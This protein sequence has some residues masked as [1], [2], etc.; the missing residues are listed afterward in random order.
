MEVLSYAVR[1]AITA[2]PGRVLYVADYAAIE[3]RVLLWLAG[4]EAALNI[5]RGGGDIYLEMAETIYD[6]PCSKSEHPAE[7]ALGK[8]AVLGL[9]YQM[10]ASKFVDTAFLMGGV[11]I[12]EE[13]AQ[14][15]VDAYRAKFPLVKAMWYATE[16]AAIEA[17]CMGKPVV[18][19]YTTWRMAG[20]FLQCV[21]PSGR[22]LS[23]PDPQV[24]P[25][26][27][28]WGEMKSQ[29]TFM[30]THPLSHKW[31]R[32]HSYGGSLVENITQAVARDLMAAALL[33]CEY[34]DT[35]VP[36][37]SVH[38]ELIA[39]AKVGTGSVREFEE[40]MAALPDW[41]EGLPVTA[42]GWTGFRYHK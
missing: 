42:E 30:G 10:G 25:K 7:R 13:M 35:Y 24:K 1:G 15:V 32:Q 23:Y 19:G 31:V 26:M 40:L 18:N 38:D 14:Q 16:E 28:P 27:T 9:G 39:E 4:D 34:S 12:D 33:R 21:L 29:L 3:A 36:V 37:L 5:F 20:R 2:S 22:A 11:T 6:H 41:A 17:V 8:V